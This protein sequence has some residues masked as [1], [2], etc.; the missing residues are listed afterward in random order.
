VFAAASPAMNLTPP[1]D[2][3]IIERLS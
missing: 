1:P 3:R 2:P